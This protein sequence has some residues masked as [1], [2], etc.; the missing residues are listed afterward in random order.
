M[1][2]LQVIST[3]LYNSVTLQFIG[4]TVIALLSEVNSFFLHSR[5][6]LQ[7]HRVP[8]NSWIYRINAWANILTF[9]IFRG[10]SLSRISYKLITDSHRF[11]RWFFIVLCCSMCIMNVMNIIFFGFLIKSD[12]LRPYFRMSAVHR[13]A[14][15]KKFPEALAENYDCFT[16]HQTKV[17]CQIFLR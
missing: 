13:Q 3:F 2:Y 9:L 14:E 12:F 8:F 6:L 16:K 7:S 17:D 5:K 11:N 4:Y 10:Y 1:T 15:A